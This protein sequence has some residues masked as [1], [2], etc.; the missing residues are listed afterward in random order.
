MQLMHMRKTNSLFY[1]HG[2]IIL[3]WRRNCV[4]LNDTR[5]FISYNLVCWRFDRYDESTHLNIIMLPYLALMKNRCG[6]S[7]AFDNFLNDC[8]LSYIA[9]PSMLLRCDIH[10]YV[11]YLVIVIVIDSLERNGR[12]NR[13]R[14]NE[15]NKKSTAIVYWIMD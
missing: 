14:R 3:P 12:D 15:H 9:Y 5:I 6:Y 10:I 7:Y 11:R 2:C 1:G 13:G 4:L 8:L